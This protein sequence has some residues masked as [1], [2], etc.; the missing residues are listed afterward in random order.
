MFQND[1]KYGR[2]ILLGTYSTVKRDG[3][4]AAGKILFEKV[5]GKKEVLKRFASKVDQRIQKYL[6]NTVFTSE[7]YTP[8]VLADL[9]LAGYQ[10]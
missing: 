6:H 2:P 9:H 10:E 1:Q 8:N 4:P 7:T 5:N 3:Y